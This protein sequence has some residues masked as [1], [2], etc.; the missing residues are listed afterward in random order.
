MINSGIRSEHSS[1]VLRKVTSTVA[2]YFILCCVAI[3]TVFPFLW[4][5]FTSFKGPTDAIFSVPPQLLPHAPTFANYVRVW[6][7][8]PVG[9]FFENSIVVTL[10]VVIFNILFTSLAAYPLAKLNFKGRNAIFY[11]LMITYIIPPALISIPSYVLAVKVFHY[12]DHIEAAIFPYLATVFNIFLLRQAMKGV[13]DDL[14]DAGRIDGASELRIW[15]DIV[16]P[17]IRPSLATVAIITFV[18]QWNNFFW[19]SLVLPTMT[20]KTLQVGLVAL[21]G[22]FVS[23]SRG[24]AA[25]VVMTV[26]PMIVFFLLLQKQFIQGLTGAVKG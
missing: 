23:D 22:A 10:N 11:L 5:F 4:V 25:G 26:V 1:A 18:E 8:L 7:M 15:W 20:N 19:P 6:N 24:T 9:R 16:I 14:I 12:Y 13:P 3:V 21:Q 2:L 17:V